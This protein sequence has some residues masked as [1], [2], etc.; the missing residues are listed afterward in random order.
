MNN[1]FLSRTAFGMYSIIFMQLNAK[2]KIQ[3]SLLTI[4]MILTGLLEVLSIGAVLPFLGVLINP[5]VILD[6]KYIQ[7]YDLVKNFLEKN[8]IVAVITASFLFFTILSGIARIML[9]WLQTRTSYSIGIDL[10]ILMYSRTLSQDYMTII[11][12]NS[13]Y[14]ISGITNKSTTIVSNAIQPFITIVSSSIMLLMI[15]LSLILIDPL[16]AIVSLFG[17]ISVYMM[18]ILFVRGRLKKNSH[19]ISIH[20]AKSLKGLQEGL[21]GIRDVL[22]N[23][24]QAKYL[25]IFANSEYPLRKAYAN[26]YVLGAIPR[27][28][29]EAFGMILIAIIAFFASKSPGGVYHAIPVLGAIALG[30]QRMLPLMQQIYT[31]WTSLTG[32]KDSIYDALEILCQ[33]VPKAKK[34]SNLNK[35][36][37]EQSIIFSDVSF[38][39]QSNQNWILQNV[40]FTIP[41]GAVI[42]VIGESG[43]GKSTLLDMLMGLLRPSTGKIYVDSEVLTEINKEEW[44]ELVSHVPQ[45]I[46]LID[47]SIEENIAISE[48]GNFI[49]YKKVEN[50]LSKAHLSELINSLKEKSKTTVGERGAKLSG[51]QIQRIGIARAI[52]KS[53]EFLVFDEATSALDDKTE[54]KIFESIN[55]LNKNATIILATHKKS[56]LNYC[57]HIISVENKTASIIKVNELL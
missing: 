43:A 26:T 52:Y 31:S 22:L 40:N 41:K 38:R 55:E 13:S 24:T 19:D 14:T 36:K 50:A 37:F 6:N 34:E 29:I 9:T 57:T 15:F 16:I 44:F 21:N 20:Q 49:D 12:R 2:R 4:F 39:Y 1:F 11:G 51:G 35:L 7:N 28:G 53:T 42:G 3:L 48:P 54:L 32:G 47:A 5:E 27:F 46:F 30:A 10:S 56:L 23:C 18:V 8:S 25:S 45:S 33:K 17:F